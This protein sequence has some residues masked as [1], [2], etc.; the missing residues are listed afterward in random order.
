MPLVRTFVG[1]ER[2]HACAAPDVIVGLGDGE[3]VGGVVGGGADCDAAGD[4]VFAGGSEY[5]CNAVGAAVGLKIGEGEMA[6]G[7]DHVAVLCR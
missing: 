4:A 3:H 2:M 1:V 7:V 5:A 6:V